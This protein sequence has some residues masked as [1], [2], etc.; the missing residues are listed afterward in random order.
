MY[1]GINPY[2]VPCQI[3]SL[4]DI[5][6]QLRKNWELTFLYLHQDNF[7]QITHSNNIS[8]PK[9]QLQRNV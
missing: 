8:T 9:K 4:K 7:C 3:D 5:D 2:Y 6:T 1:Q